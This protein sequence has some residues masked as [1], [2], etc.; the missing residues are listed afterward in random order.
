MLVTILYYIG[1][2]PSDKA[3]RIPFKIVFVAQME[4]ILN[5]NIFDDNHHLSNSTLNSSQCQD[6]IEIRNKVKSAAKNPQQKRGGYK[7][8]HVVNASDTVSITII[9]KHILY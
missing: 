1:K 5:S 8:S 6:F 9:V 4:K 7:T 3:D 2:F